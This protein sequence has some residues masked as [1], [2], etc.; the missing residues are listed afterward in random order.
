MGRVQ[1]FDTTVA[2]QAARNQFWEHGYEGTSLADLEE[3][4]GLNRSSL[5]HAFTSKRGLFDAAVENYLDTVIRP[6][7]RVLANAETADAS[8]HGSRDALVTY[9]DGLATALAVREEGAGPSGCLLVNSAAGLAGHDE[10]L[11]QVVDSYRSE[12]AEAIATAVR[13]RS[14]QLAQQV[15]EHR[16]RLLSALSVSALLL[17]R[18][19]R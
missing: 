18:V 11:R 5:Y 12:L 6:R 8:V 19:N 9:F 4:T 10:A 14:T 3:V 15:V 17:V 13:A 2:V 7:I 1:T 16:T